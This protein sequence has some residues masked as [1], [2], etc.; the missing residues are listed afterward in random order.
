MPLSGSH[1]EP[2]GRCRKNVVKNARSVRKELVRIVVRTRRRAEAG[3]MA[4]IAYLAVVLAA[5]ASCAL[6]VRALGATQ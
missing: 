6:V 1:P 2:D 5:F 3:V 4:D